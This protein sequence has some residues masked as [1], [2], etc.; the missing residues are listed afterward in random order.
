[1]PGIHAVARV[2]CWVMLRPYSS[3]TNS[4][5]KTQNSKLTQRFWPLLLLLALVLFPFG[6][7]GEQIP[8]F[9]LFL[10]WLFASAREHAIGHTLLFLLLG[11]AA[12]FTFPGLARRPW[13]YLGLMLL[14]AIFQEGFQLLYKA[15]PLVFDDFRDLV[16]DMIGSLLALGLIR[17]WRWK[18]HQNV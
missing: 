11:L 15:R 13:H 9:G 2:A 12:L 16:T 18:K 5:L 14:V 17:V 6:W 3:M 10:G 8:G 7:L 4:K 1:M